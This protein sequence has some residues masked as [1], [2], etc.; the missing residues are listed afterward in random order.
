MMIIEDTRQKKDKHIIKNKSF[1]SL[2]VEVV[3][4]A[5][6]FGDYAYPPPIAVDTKEN[7]QEIAMDLGVEHER[8]RNECLLAR[9]AGSQLYILIETEWDNIRTIDDV[10]LWYNPRLIVTRKAITGATLEKAMK[11]MNKKYGVK[12]M[13]CRPEEAAETIIKILNGDFEDGQSNIRGR[14]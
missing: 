12:F 8:F 14:P 1:E 5:L 3:R 6:P 2:G 9:R 11:T 13:F 10:H 7:L 4:R